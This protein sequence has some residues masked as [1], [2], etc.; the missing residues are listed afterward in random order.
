MENEYLEIMPD[1]GSPG[2]LNPVQ[3]NI[4]SDSDDY[5]KPYQVLKSQ[6][7]NPVVNEIPKLEN[8]KEESQEA[9]L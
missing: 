9:D 1:S 6:T 4:S 5:A 2:Y 7:Q 8:A 3:R